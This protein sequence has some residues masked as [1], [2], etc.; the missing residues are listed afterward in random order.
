MNHTDYDE[1]M[2]MCPPADAAQQRRIGITEV[3]PAE[4]MIKVKC[5]ACGNEVWLGVKLQAERAKCKQAKVIC[6]ECGLRQF[7]KVSA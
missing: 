5:E 7:G 3:T 1:I 6:Y 4:G 2:L